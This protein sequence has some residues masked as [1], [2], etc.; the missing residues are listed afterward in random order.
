MASSCGSIEE[1]ETLPWV[2]PATSYALLHERRHSDA[3]RSRG[4][5]GTC[6]ARHAACDFGSSR[7]TG[8]CD[9]E[10]IARRHHGRRARLTPRKARWLASLRRSARDV[11]RASLNSLAAAAGNRRSAARDRLGLE[12][13]GGRGLAASSHRCGISAPHPRFGHALRQRRAARALARLGAG[14]L[15]DGRHSAGDRRAGSRAGQG[16]TRRLRISR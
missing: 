10:R 11:T 2:L 4:S 6:R 14:R 13:S 3:R 1:D 8:G 12:R 7:R 16:S 5:S 9:H 15:G